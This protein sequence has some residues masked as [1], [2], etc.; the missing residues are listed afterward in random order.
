MG[1]LYSIRISA[2][3]SIVLSQ[4][5]HTTETEGN[6]VVN[7]ALHSMQHGKQMKL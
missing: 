1:L 5:T 4:V 7:T 6:L 3:V 2:G